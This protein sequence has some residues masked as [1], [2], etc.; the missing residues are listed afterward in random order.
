MWIV[1]M[2]NMIF[3]DIFTII[4]EIANKSAFNELTNVTMTM[5][6][7][8]VAT[9][10]PILMIYFSRKLNHKANRPVNIIAAAFTILYVT[11]GGMAT[12]HYII[13]AG[14]EIIFLVAIIAKAWKWEE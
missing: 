3:A 10:I 5:A 14:I 13:I 8:A 6:I 9:N 2:I 11:L 4:V 12:L 7:A 1:V